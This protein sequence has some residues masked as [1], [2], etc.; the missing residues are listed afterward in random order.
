MCF[1]KVLNYFMDCVKAIDLKLFI[2]IYVTIW[3]AVFAISLP[4][5][6]RFD[7]NRIRD[8]KLMSY[9]D[10]KY[11]LK[12]KRRTWFIFALLISGI[13][14]FTL[15]IPFR[16]FY[17]CD[18]IFLSSLINKSA[19]IFGIFSIIFYIITSFMHLSIPKGSHFLSKHEF[20]TLIKK[21]N[22][23]Q[24][25]EP[26]QNLTNTQRKILLYII[27]AE[28][29]AYE[30]LHAQ[31]KDII[32]GFL[33]NLI[34]IN[35]NCGRNQV[36]DIFL[37]EYLNK[38]IINSKTSNYLLK[39]IFLIDLSNSPEHKKPVDV[40][41]LWYLYYYIS[42]SPNY[43]LSFWSCL[44]QYFTTKVSQNPGMDDL[45]EL[46]KINPQDKD[47]IKNIESYRQ[48]LLILGGLLLYKEKF[49]TLNKIVFFSTSLP[50]NY[51]LLP[52]SMNE[53]F[54][55]ASDIESEWYAKYSQYNFIKDG[56]ENRI[57]TP[58]KYIAEY[59]GVLFLSQWSK[60]SK[61]GRELTGLPE[62]PETEIKIEKLL[63]GANM[64]QRV[65]DGLYKDKR[66]QS[67]FTFPEKSII[68]KYFDNLGAMCK[69]KKIKNVKESE[70]SDK[71]MKRIRTMI[72]NSFADKVN[73][74]KDL[75]ELITDGNE[76]TESK[77]RFSNILTY[78][79]R[80]VTTSLEKS[81]L[82]E[83]SIP[84]MNLEE[85]IAGSILF[86][87]FDKML[88]SSLKEVVNEYHILDIND[89]KDIL[90][91]S[92]FKN[93]D[94][95]LVIS[96]NLNT[97]NVPKSLKENIKELPITPLDEY[98]SLII[99]P[100]ANRPILK[101][102]SC[103]SE[104][105]RLKKFDKVDDEIDLWERK[106]EKPLNKSNETKSAEDYKIDLSYLLNY[107]FVSQ[108]QKG[109]MIINFNSRFK[110]YGEVSDVKRVKEAIIKLI[111]QI[112]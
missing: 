41:Y 16:P 84:L 89:L 6:N 95:I 34:L 28:T 110:D 45:Y 36:I 10:V 70:L 25:K 99:L 3:S 88:Y 71:T 56:T 104:E 58:A 98:N 53:I 54:F 63:M 21:F 81:F 22:K 90:G 112:K 94:K 83:G 96:A 87:T 80:T 109:G 33:R 31:A 69:V 37:N 47:L 15:I 48:I 51:P 46:K 30:S 66:L 26:Q 68:D 105:L 1:L 100:N 82:I 39:G 14:L 64:L 62:I 43:L 65:I 27:E 75:Y 52:Q 59:L 42:D 107:S 17:N 49:E 19:L 73:T 11:Y 101:N 18:N 92:I 50:E 40:S 103:T 20:E 24:S 5:D 13:S 32:D 60:T 85:S 102:A 4:L 2:Q 78:P 29:N 7:T 111:K 93:N 74:H 76:Y 9:L 23:E 72:K 106:I 12:D 86:E 67:F 108:P 55:W 8:L 79:F 61:Y 57:D 91:L 38:K 77:L 35:L 44:C 97:F